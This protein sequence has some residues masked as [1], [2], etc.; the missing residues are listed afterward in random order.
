MKSSTMDFAP[1]AQVCGGN[2]DALEQ[3]IA[4]FPI[5]DIRN[6]CKSIV[7]QGEPVNSQNVLQC[8]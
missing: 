5:R 6:F 4:V 3:K 1:L 8:V 2:V 7:L